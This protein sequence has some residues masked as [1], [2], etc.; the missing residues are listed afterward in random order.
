MATSKPTTRGRAAPPRTPTLTPAAE[1][2]KRGLGELK[3]LPSGATVCV[4]RPSLFAMARA[5]HVP[6]PLL[7]QVLPHLVEN[8]QDGAAAMDD[9]ELTIEQRTARYR[10]NATIYT[11]IAAI[12]VAEPRIILD[13]AP[14]YDAGEI[15]PEDLSV[16]DL[17]W[18]YTYVMNGVEINLEVA[19][20][21]STFS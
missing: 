3:T 9:P 8:E 15:A 19:D 2:K 10:E 7:E 21:G 16:S 20:D 18:I 11:A 13:R 4:K 1:W 12:A 6:N 17:I 14:D 5:G